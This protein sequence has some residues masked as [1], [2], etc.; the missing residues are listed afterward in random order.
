MVD[1]FQGFQQGAGV[2]PVP[3]DFFSA[4][5][6]A[7][8]D[9]AELKLTLTCMWAL[10]QQP[11]PYRHLHR[12]DLFSEV[13]R[14]MHGLSDDAAIRAALD[15]AVARGSLLLHPADTDSADAL[16]FA[17]SPAGR[18]AVERLRLGEALDLTPG[19]PL[20]P[21]RP[22]IYT[23]YE[24]NIGPLTPLIAQ[25]LQDMAAE[26]GVDHLH[27]AISIS[28]QKEKR[29][30]HYVRGILRSW[31]REGKGDEGSRRGRTGADGM[32]SR[33]DT[34]AG[35]GAATDDRDDTDLTGD[36]ADFFE[37]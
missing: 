4:L 7:I 23:L 3:A 15:A 35:R 26:F 9:A 24:Q 32:G 16:V 25:E 21:P 11:G 29:S 10:T 34:H 2:V 13:A 18:E 12:A 14:T 27:E 5:L 28:V 30:L 8:D 33:R 19:A 6:P 1:V 31:R 17:N 20:L 36:Y 22:G 37:R